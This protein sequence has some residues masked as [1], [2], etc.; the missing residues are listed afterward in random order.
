[1]LT[2]DPCFFCAI[3]SL[4]ELMSRPLRV[5]DV[6]EALFHGGSEGS[7]EWYKGVSAVTAHLA[8]C[9]RLIFLFVTRNY[10]ERE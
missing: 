8:F 7:E 1:V 6:V 2:T 4:H 3:K 9:F 10:R 5:G